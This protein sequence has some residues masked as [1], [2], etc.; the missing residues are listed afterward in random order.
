MRIIVRNDRIAA[1]KNVTWSAL[2]SGATVAANITWLSSIIPR[3]LQMEWQAFGVGVEIILDDWVF[4]IEGRC[5]IARVSRR[6]MLRRKKKNKAPLAPESG[7]LGDRET[8]AHME[9]TAATVWAALIKSFPIIL[10]VR[11]IIFQLLGAEEIREEGLR[12]LCNS[13]DAIPWRTCV[14]TLKGWIIKKKGN[15]AFP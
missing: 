2:R 5:S 13:F 7:S 15:S 8:R 11:S 9:E 3:R 12:Y 10:V 1:I 14:K 6:E 4:W